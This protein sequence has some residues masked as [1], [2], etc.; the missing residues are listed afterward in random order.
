LA[1]SL[2]HPP[3]CG[4]QLREVKNYVIQSGNM[5]LLPIT[6]LAGTFSFSY[7]EFQKKFPIL[8]QTFAAMSIQQGFDVT[9]CLHIE[10]LHSRM[11]YQTLLPVIQQQEALLKDLPKECMF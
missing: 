6:R 5:Q 1:N 7:Y 2:Y 11:E 9:R 8:I 10:L 4:N 3:L